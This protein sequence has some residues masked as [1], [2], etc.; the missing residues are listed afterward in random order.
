[1]VASGVGAV[2][3]RNASAADRICIKRLCSLFDMRHDI[4][5]NGRKLNISSECCLRIGNRHIAERVVIPSFEYGVGVYFEL[6]IEVTIGSA[7]QAGLTLAFYR[8]HVACIYTGRNMDR[9]ILF[10]DS[11]ASSIAC[12]TSCIA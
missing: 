12:G 6:D 7:A 1:M 8:H 10:L 9:K 4:A 5:V 2:F 11:P 3:E